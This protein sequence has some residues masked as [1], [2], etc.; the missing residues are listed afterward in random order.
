MMMNN[1]FG[2]FTLAKEAIEAMAESGVV[3]KMGEL[4]E[5]LKEEIN[6]VIEMDMEGSG[7][8]PEDF[9]R[10]MTGLAKDLYGCIRDFV[11]KAEERY[12][13]EEILEDLDCIE[14]LDIADYRSNSYDY[15][16]LSQAK[17]ACKEALRKAISDARQNLEEG[18]AAAAQLCGQFLDR[19][20]SD[21]RKFLKEYS[22]SFDDYVS[23]ECEG[24]AEGFAWRQKSAV[25]D[26]W[27]IYADLGIRQ[28]LASLMDKLLDRTFVDAL[29]VKRYFEECRYDDDCESFCYDADEAIESL[30]EAVRELYQTAC[31]KLEKGMEELYLSSLY[32]FAS[33]LAGNLVGLVR[34]VGT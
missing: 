11:E 20:D 1:I 13:E 16:R 7:C 31:I 32:D 6:Q 12:G 24:E 17:V 23:L 29:D 5:D 26:G 19:M 30:D 9:Y 8:Y 4:E 28:E 21:I 33:E 34:T 10:Q 2:S 18:K 27:E 14:E 3:R 15:E 25:T 22:D